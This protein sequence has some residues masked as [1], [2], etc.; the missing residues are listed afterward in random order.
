MGE[1]PSFFGIFTKMGES[2]SFF[3]RKIMFV[4][5][6]YFVLKIKIIKLI[7]SSTTR[8]EKIYRINAR[9]NF[10]KNILIKIFHINTERRSMFKK[11]TN[12]FF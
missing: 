9:Y 12:H 8:I 2:P 3:V 4:M 5:F 11:T 6:E 1:S 10:A 7:I